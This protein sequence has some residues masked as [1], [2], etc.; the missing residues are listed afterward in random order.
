MIS[1]LAA[2]VGGASDGKTYGNARAR[3]NGRV[4][5]HHPFVA[6]VVGEPALQR[7]QRWRASRRGHLR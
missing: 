1:E 2:G 4:A 6:V 3:S 7:G 5:A